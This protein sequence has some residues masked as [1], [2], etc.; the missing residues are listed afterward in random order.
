VFIKQHL[1]VAGECLL[2]FCLVSSVTSEHSDW[3][4]CPQSDLF[5]IML[6]VKPLSINS[7]RTLLLK[8]WHI[9]IIFLADF[10]FMHDKKYSYF[11]MTTSIMI[12]LLDVEH[13]CITWLETELS[14]LFVFIIPV[15]I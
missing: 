1:C 5:C 3:E 6:D 7:C 15:Y 8:C 9:F 11:V 2:S 13:L 14:F 4:E 12:D 10:Y